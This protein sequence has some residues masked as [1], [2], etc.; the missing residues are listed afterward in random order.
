MKE[1]K[2]YDTVTDD[3]KGFYSVVENK[4]AYDVIYIYEEK[5]R[6]LV[7][8]IQNSGKKLNYHECIAKTRKA[9]EIF[10]GISELNDKYKKRVA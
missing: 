1:I 4:G 9:A 5:T 3:A 2:K 6:K 8:V 10:Q 7:G